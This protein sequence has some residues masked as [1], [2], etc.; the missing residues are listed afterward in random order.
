MSFLTSVDV[1]TLLGCQIAL[2]LV[3]AIVFCCMKGMYPYLRGT[4]QVTKPGTVGKAWAMLLCSRAASAALRL[5]ARR[6]GFRRAS[7]IASLE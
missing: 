4:G 2:T 7:H 3:Y 6:I 5:F 1:G